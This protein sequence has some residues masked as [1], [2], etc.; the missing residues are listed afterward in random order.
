M[1]HTDGTQIAAISIEKESLSSSP[2]LSLPLPIES[3]GFSPP[4]ST[5][6]SRSPHSQVL[7]AASVT[8]GKGNRGIARR[9]VRLRTEKGKNNNGTPGSNSGNV[10]VGLSWGRKNEVCDKII[11]FPLFYDQ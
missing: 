5:T 2:V 3:T 9:T 7:L 11:Y 4:K 10:G 1:N 8:R 6:R